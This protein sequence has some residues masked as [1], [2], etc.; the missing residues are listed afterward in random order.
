MTTKKLNLVISGEDSM[1][2]DNE[3]LTDLQIDQYKHERHGRA[4]P[5]LIKIQANEEDIYY[6]H[7]NGACFAYSYNILPDMY[8]KSDLYRLLYISI[9][10]KNTKVA[11][12]INKKLLSLSVRETIS[13]IKNIIKI[14]VK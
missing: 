12:K 13:L 3:L 4:M 1:F 5:V 6:D 9:S 14:L 2:I 7:E 10:N 11:L 8:K